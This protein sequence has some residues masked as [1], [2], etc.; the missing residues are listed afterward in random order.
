MHQWTFL[1]M[2]LQHFN[3]D[4]LVSYPG[5]LHS[6]QGEQSIGPWGH[7]HLKSYS[8]RSKYVVPRTYP[9]TLNS[10]RPISEVL[11]D[12]FWGSSYRGHSLSWTHA[13]GPRGWPMDDYWSD[14][15][16]DLWT[17]YQY[18]CVPCLWWDRHGPSR[19]NWEWAQMEAVASIYSLSTALH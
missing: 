9:S 17:G 8:P 4:S 3:L 18:T 5:T 16:L 14:Y 19:S 6:L 2:I 1:P 12:V 7:A 10:L 15:D 11:A 13:L